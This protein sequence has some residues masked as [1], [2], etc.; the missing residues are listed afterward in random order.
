MYQLHRLVRRWLLK[1][2][3]CKK[4]PARLPGILQR[5]T[6]HCVTKFLY[7]V[8]Y[9]IPL[10]FAF[11]C[12]LIY[13]SSCV[14]KVKRNLLTSTERNTIYWLSFSNCFHYTKSHLSRYIS[15]PCLIH[16]QDICFQFVCQ[17][18]CLTLALIKSSCSF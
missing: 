9:R 13:Y 3:S 7:N 15:P 6:A 11:T 10:C 17:N 18:N 2:V 5:H 14:G 8:H 12:C 1:S 4:K 16:Q